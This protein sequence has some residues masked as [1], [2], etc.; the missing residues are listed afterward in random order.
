MVAA[1]PW[2]FPFSNNIELKHSEMING[3]SIAHLTTRVR[4]TRSP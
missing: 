3:Y 4:G 2:A 1:A